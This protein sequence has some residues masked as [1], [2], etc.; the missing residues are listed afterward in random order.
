MQEQFGIPE[1]ADG[2]F[3][4]AMNN[5]PRGFNMPSAFN[6]GDL[7]LDELRTLGYITEASF[8]THFTSSSSDE[9]F[10]DFGPY[11][12]EVMSSLDD[13]VEIVIE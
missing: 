3:G 2:I 4:L 6:L 13:Y 10:V 5:T 12:E 11:R 7:Y 1:S 8:S 9:S